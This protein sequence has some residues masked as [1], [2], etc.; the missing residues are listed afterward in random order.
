M[1]YILCYYLDHAYSNIKVDI[2]ISQK[3]NFAM[4]LIMEALYNWILT[5]Q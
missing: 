4:S 5:I 3:R 2:Y 1:K